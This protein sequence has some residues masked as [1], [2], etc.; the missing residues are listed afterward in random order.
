[1]PWPLALQTLRMPTVKRFQSVLK[2]DTM[3]SSM[4]RKGDYR[5]N[6]RA[7][8]TVSHLKFN[9]QLFASAGGTAESCIR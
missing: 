9:K 2:D 5:G 8:Q 1:M 7:E 6:A 4:N 3:K